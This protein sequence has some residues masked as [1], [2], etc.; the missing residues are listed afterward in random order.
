MKQHKRLRAHFFRDIHAF[1]PSRMSPA[2]ANR[3]QLLRRILRVIN[4]DIGA[5]CEFPE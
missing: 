3:R 2:L 4:K 1:Q 5:L